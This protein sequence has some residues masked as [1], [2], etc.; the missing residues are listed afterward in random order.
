MKTM[1]LQEL[2]ENMELATLT[3]FAKHRNGTY[4]SL[5]LS[6]QS[7]ELLDNFVEMNLGLKERVDKSTYHITVI[8]SRS[9]VPTAENLLHMHT[10]LPVE[11][12]VTGYEVFPTKNDGK[13]LVMRLDCPFATRLNADLTKQGATSDYDQYKAHLTIA[14]DM[15]QEINPQELPIPMFT[16]EFDKLNVDAL[17]PEF[18][19]S[20]K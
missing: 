4:V 18:I 12:Q 1:S 10:P 8:Y 6:K 19:P 7:K 14:Y 20:N 13:C 2:K 16:L 17:D 3:Q 9:P 15:A 11:A 5:N